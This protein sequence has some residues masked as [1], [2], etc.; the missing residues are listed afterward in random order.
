MAVTF[1][2]NGEFRSGEALTFMILL[3]LS[4]YRDKRPEDTLEVTV[5][6]SLSLS[7]SME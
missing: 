3:T 1:R 4:T 6:V 7:G 5:W 2:L